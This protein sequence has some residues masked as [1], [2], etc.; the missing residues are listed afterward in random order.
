MPQREYVSKEEESPYTV[1]IDA[2]MLSCEIDAR[3]TN[4][5]Q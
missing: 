5:L 4:M 1:S 2:M 3:K